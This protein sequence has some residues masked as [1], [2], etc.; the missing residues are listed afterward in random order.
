MLNIWKRRASSILVRQK[1][2]LWIEVWVP[3][4]VADLTYKLLKVFNLCSPITKKCILPRHEAVL[5]LVTNSINTIYK[6][7][8]MQ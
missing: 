1:S 8:F 6:D 2:D 4:H 5:L 7:S 3:T